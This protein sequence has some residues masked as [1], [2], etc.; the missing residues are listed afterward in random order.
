MNFSWLSR[1]RV[2]FWQC[3]AI[4]L[5]LAGPAYAID[6]PQWRGPD[7]IGITSEKINTSWPPAGPKVLWRASIGTGFCSLSIS[8]GRLYT[9]GNASE[10]ETL[11][12]FDAQTGKVIWKHTYP[13]PLGPVYYEGGPG[14]TPT[15]EANHVY[16]IGK[17]GDAFCLDAATGAVV[18]QHDLRKD[19][20]KTNRWGF[21]GSPLIWHELVIFNAGSAG[22]ALERA[23]GKLAWSNGPNP[24]AYAS[25]T[26]FHADGQE[27]VLIFAA[28]HLVAVDPKD[29]HELWRYPWETG[30]DTNNSDPLIYK[31]QIFISSYSRGCALLKVVQ[32]KPEPVYTSEI[33]HN[34]LSPGILLGEN[35]YAFNG[36]AK[37]QSDL[38]CIHLPTGT[39]KWT[40]KDP[41][42]GSFIL[43]GGTLLIL[44]EKGELIAAQPSPDDFKPEARAQVL[45][46]LCW[47]PPALANGLLYAHNA[48][49]DLVC[50]DLRP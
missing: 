26:L 44:S 42:M 37:Q 14:S 48:K 3:L 13:S 32:G 16:S 39:M 36:E 8:H 24:T 27:Y 1:S 10:Q 4:Y 20:I 49:G 23:S 33:L 43:A 38:R 28:K 41:A 45:G 47:A 19:G 17:W 15:I 29:G 7:R 11:W 31:N 46:G 9:I 34:H 5:L 25:P 22:V 35:L 12:C 2:S 6:W 40:R 18:W 30:Y 21:A 50:L